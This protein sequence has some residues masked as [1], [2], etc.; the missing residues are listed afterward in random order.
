MKNSTTKTNIY[1]ITRVFDK[2]EKEYNVK[3]NKEQ[4]SYLKD[5]WKLLRVCDKNVK[6]WFQYDVTMEFFKEN[7][8]TFFG[9]G[10]KVETTT[11]VEVEVE[12]KTEQ[13][14]TVIKLTQDQP[15]IIEVDGRM[16]ELSYKE[17]SGKE[18]ST[19]VEFG[20]NEKSNQNYNGKIQTTHGWVKGQ[21]QYR[22]MKEEILN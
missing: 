9:L 18:E 17:R 2:I 6:G 5:E 12:T 15:I 1:T 11:E 22:N 20:I 16:I 14:P 10:A 7:K 19:L 3:L 4:K 21:F 13:K 8:E